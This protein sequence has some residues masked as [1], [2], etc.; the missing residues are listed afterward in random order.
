MGM[1]QIFKTERWAVRLNDSVCVGIVWGE[2]GEVLGNKDK[3]EV[4]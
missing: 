4:R 2:G 1:S 3:F